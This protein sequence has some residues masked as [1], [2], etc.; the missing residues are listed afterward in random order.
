MQQHHPG[1][2]AAAETGLAGVRREAP[3]QQ[4]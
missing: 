4:D 2:I 1:R 3:L